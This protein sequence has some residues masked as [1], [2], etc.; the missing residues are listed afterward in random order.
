MKTLFLLRH[1]KSSWKR[2]ELPDRLRPLN[3][4]GREAA[5]AMGRLLA[6]ESLWPDLILCSSAARTRETCDRLLT[7]SSAAISVRYLDELYHSTVERMFEALQG[8]SPDVARLL[9]IGHNPEFAEF[10]AVVAGYQEKFPTGGLAALS[11]DIAGWSE[12]RVRQ[13]M[14]LKGLWRPRDLESSTG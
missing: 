14:M 9:I 6:K 10:L 13:P 2:P 7:A 12:L 11:I 4:R 5:L 3:R 8:I 1:A